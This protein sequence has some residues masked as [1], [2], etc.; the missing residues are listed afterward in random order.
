M[1]KGG[2]KFPWDDTDGFLMD[3]MFEAARS[4]N[5][6]YAT[7]GFITVIDYFFKLEQLRDFIK[8]IKGDICLTILLPDCDTNII[9]DENRQWTIG[10][11]RIKF[12]ND[13]YSRIKDKCANFIL[14]N[15][16]MEL[17]DVVQKIRQAPKYS[18]NDAINMLY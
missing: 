8:E 3:T 6:T 17:E 18:S 16:S 15:S 4:V 2:Y 11:E 5:S 10:A 12:Y 13:Y 1:V 9:R 7:K 14:D